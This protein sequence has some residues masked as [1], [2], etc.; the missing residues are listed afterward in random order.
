MG[1]DEPAIDHASRPS[2][3]LCACATPQSGAFWLM[4]FLIVTPTVPRTAPAPEPV[5]GGTVSVG[6]TGLLSGTDGGTFE[7]TPFGAEVGKG[8][9]VTMRP[10]AGASGGPKTGELMNQIEALALELQALI[11]RAEHPV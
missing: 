2:P 4:S 3:P 11:K 6:G 5:A 10:A 8:R 7:A 9:P 1:R